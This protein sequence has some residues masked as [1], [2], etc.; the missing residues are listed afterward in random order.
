MPGTKTEAVLRMTGIIRRRLGLSDATPPLPGGRGHSQEAT[1]T[2]PLIART[3][4]LR[5]G[6]AGPQ[7][8]S[9]TSNSNYF[10]NKEVGVGRILRPDKRIITS[11]QPTPSRPSVRPGLLAARPSISP[12]LPGRTLAR[13]C[14][15]VCFAISQCFLI[16][17]SS[18][19]VSVPTY[20]SSRALYPTNS[21]SQFS[22]PYCPPRSPRGWEAQ[23][24]QRL[25]D[26]PAG[27]T[28]L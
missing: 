21:F 13:P 17:W 20:P 24:T 22:R 28:A 3:L 2:P 7:W 18:R 12:G 9:N 1:P 14:L 26:P 6:A 23:H 19:W 5:D 27:D 8:R 15:L 10:H 16:R 11:G 4:P 25:H